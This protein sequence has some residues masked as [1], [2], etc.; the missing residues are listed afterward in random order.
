M[1]GRTNIVRFIRG[2]APPFHG[3]GVTPIKPSAQV[4]RTYSFIEKSPT[5]F[6]LDNVKNIYYNKIRKKGENVNS[7]Q[8][9]KLNWVKNGSPLENL[10]ICE[11]YQQE[12]DGISPSKREEYSQKVYLQA[13]RKFVKLKNLCEEKQHQ[14]EELIE[15]FTKNEEN[16][17]FLKNN[18]FA[19]NGFV[20]LTDEKY[21][22]GVEPKFTKE[23]KIYF[24]NAYDILQ[25]LDNLAVT[26]CKMKNE[27]TLM[28]YITNQN[29]LLCSAKQFQKEYKMPAGEIPFIN[30]EYSSIYRSIYKNLDTYLQNLDAF[31]VKTWKQSLQNAQDIQK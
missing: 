2:H 23:Q 31:A 15:N 14:L 8:Q 13:M 22:Y 16:N 21:F 3:V 17:I 30:K 11:K 25:Q 9:Q 18:L 7:I 27:K 10:G 12:L 24:D 1:T 6:L 26:F 20:F 19:F 29:K 28:E 4:Q 5:F